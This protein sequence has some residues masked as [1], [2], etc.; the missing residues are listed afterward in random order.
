MPTTVYAAS[1]NKAVKVGFKDLN[2]RN[3]GIAFRLDDAAYRDTVERAL[4][5]MKSDGTLHARCM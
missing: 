4:E 5:C 2:G 3:F 1:R